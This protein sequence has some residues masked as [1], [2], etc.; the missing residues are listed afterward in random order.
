[1]IKISLTSNVY[2]FSYQIAERPQH[3]FW[4]IWQIIDSP[5]D[6]YILGTNSELR[7]ELRCSGCIHIIR[8]NSSSHYTLSFHLIRGVSLPLY[9]QREK[10][11]TARALTDW[12]LISTGLAHHTLDLLKNTE[13]PTAISTLVSLAGMLSSWRFTFEPC[14]SFLWQKFD[15]A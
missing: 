13:T 7:N 4:I 8:G 1:M 11:D 14:A 6:R 9:E 15:F 10:L 12:F 5:S 2:S 3:V